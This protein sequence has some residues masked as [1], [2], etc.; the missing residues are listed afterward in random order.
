MQYKGE[1]QRETEGKE[2]NINYKMLLKMANNM[3]RIDNK[4]KQN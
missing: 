4:Q 2:E 1:E 3:R